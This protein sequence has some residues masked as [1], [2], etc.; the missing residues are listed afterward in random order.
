MLFISKNP[1][2]IA[3]LGRS[4]NAILFWGVITLLLVVFGTFAGASA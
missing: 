4:I 2:R 3:K 1:D